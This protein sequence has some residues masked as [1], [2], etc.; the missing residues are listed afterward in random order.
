MTLES[1]RSYN[2]LAVR[3]PK[4]I[5]DALRVSDGRRAEIRVE[6]GTLVLRPLLKPTA[7]AVCISL[8][9]LGPAIRIADMPCLEGIMSKRRD[10]RISPGRKDWIKVKN[11]T[12]PAMIR[13]TDALGLTTWSSS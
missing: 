13:V 10:G 4:A 1:C 8:A 3:I 12:H 6:N 9:Q 7:V 2:S 5:A 11:R